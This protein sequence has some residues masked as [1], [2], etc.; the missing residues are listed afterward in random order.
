MSSPDLGAARFADHATKLG[1]IS[2][3][4]TT[5]ERAGVALVLAGDVMRRTR[6]LSNLQQSAGRALE[7]IDA[8]AARAF[9]DSIDVAAEK[10]RLEQA[11]NDAFECMLADPDERPTWRDRALA[12]LAYRDRLTSVATALTLTGNDARALTEK[13]AQVDAGLSK[14]AR[15]LVGLNGARR[16]ERD[17][18]DATEQAGA[19]WFSA[20]SQCDRLAALYTGEDTRSDA[21]IESCEDCRRDVKAASGASK[22]AH[23]DAESLRRREDGSASAGELMWMD[24]HAKSCNACKRALEALSIP[25]EG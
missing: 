15:M 2:G 20:R 14:K 16:A 3:P 7:K 6:A 13:L 11:L 12:G 22:P 25:L 19:W 1:E 17:A 10:Q 9:V 5:A 18:L 4:V 23:V 21:H 8:A 24:S